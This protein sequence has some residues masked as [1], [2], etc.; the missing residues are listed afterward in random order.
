[1]VS[2]LVG[3]LVGVVAVTVA[4]AVVVVAVVAVVVV[5]RAVAAVAVVVVAVVAAV[6]AVARAVAVVLLFFTVPFSGIENLM[7]LG[8]ATN[9][10]LRLTPRV[11]IA[12]LV[13]C[14]QKSCASDSQRPSRSAQEL[15]LTPRARKP[16][17]NRQ[18]PKTCARSQQWQ[19]L[20]HSEERLHKYTPEKSA[21][22]KLAM[23]H[24]LLQETPDVTWSVSLP[25]VE[26]IRFQLGRRRE[27]EPSLLQPTTE[28]TWS[29]LPAKQ[30]E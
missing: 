22:S 6:A 21:R 14:S 7:T 26:D 24:I 29:P 3:W 25:A 27:L 2:W 19:W 30:T 17:L 10:W 13:S 4:V 12:S 9:F 8:F 11:R 28:I 5:A 16:S 15:R 1:M 23:L 20:A 18:S